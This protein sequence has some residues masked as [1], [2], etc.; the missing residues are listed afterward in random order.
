[1]KK[2]IDFD[3]RNFQKELLSKSPLNLIVNPKFPKF[4]LFETDNKKNG[5]V[6]GFDVNNSNHEGIART[7]DR[8]I[9]EMKQAYIREIEIDNNSLGA[10]K[11]DLIE[12]IFAKKYIYSDYQFNCFYDIELGV[13]L[14]IVRFIENEYG[15]AWNSTDLWITQ[16]ESIEF[17]C[18]T[19]FMP[20]QMAIDIVQIITRVCQSKISLTYK[21][22]ELYCYE[23]GEA[24]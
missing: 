2:Y 1:M 19:D 15:T 6:Y 21:G 18:L 10:Q 11:A 4:E 13:K 23:N 24:I 8:A 16:N 14:Q 22:K 7:L 12:D 17:R 3:F 5:K 20:C 9:E